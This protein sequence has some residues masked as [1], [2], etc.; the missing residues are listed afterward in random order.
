MGP[1]RHRSDELGTRPETLE[2]LPLE[3]RQIIYD[4]IVQYDHLYDT[5]KQDIN[6]WLYVG[7][8]QWVEEGDPSIWEYN[9]TIIVDSTTDAFFSFSSHPLLLR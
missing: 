5:S 7:R 3:I 8:H 4:F 2:Q 6:T 9:W 1:A